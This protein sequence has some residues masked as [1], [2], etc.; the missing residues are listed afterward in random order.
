MR[1]YQKYNYYLRRGF[2][3]GKIKKKMER[4]KS[5]VS[6]YTFKYEKSWHGSPYL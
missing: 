2:F 6:D 1:K 4:V 3:F 5:N